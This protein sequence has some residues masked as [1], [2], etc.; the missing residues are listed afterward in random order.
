MLGTV[1]LPAGYLNYIGKTIRV[2]GKLTL[3]PSTGGTDQLIVGIGDTTDFTT[4]T[5]KAVCTLTQTTAITTA[6]Q[7]QYFS[8]VMTVNAT[9]TTGAIMPSGFSIL[10]VAS[11]VAAG[12]AAVESATAA[13]T[14]DVLNQSTL[15]IE[16]LQTSAAESTTPPQLQILNV[17]EL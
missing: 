2:S 8:C 9:G 12:A 14:A 16:F 13:I 10:Q 11:G 7:S 6:A 15:N 17:E 1:P 3:T 5:P 4:G